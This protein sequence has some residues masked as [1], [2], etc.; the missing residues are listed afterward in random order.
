M[1]QS[2][3]CYIRQGSSYLMLL[4]NKKKNDINEG[5]WIGVGGKFEQGEDALQCARREILEET[6]LYAV[7][8][9]YEG[10]IHFHYHHMEDE[11]IFV[12][13]CDDFTG[14]LKECNEGTLAWIPKDK[15]MSL[16][17]WEGDRLFLKRILEP[18][19]QPFVFDLEYDENGNL[20]SATEK[21]GSI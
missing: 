17:L 1:I 3:V 11:D 6:G 2:T 8:L 5:K 15:I 12:Y 20:I 21:E 4:R 13:T 16:P 7:Q 18:D 19:E 9:H 10:I 14:T